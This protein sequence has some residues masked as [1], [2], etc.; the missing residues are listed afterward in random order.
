MAMDDEPNPEPAIHEIIPRSGRKIAIGSEWLEV[1]DAGHV[2][3]FIDVISEARQANGV[4][5]LS[6]GGG[7]IE[8][9]AAFCQIESRLRMNLGTAQFLH[10][11]LGQMIEDALKPVDQSKAN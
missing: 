7:V 5:Y 6:F 4:V 8:G 10:R 2:P 3:K 11:L 9:N 1:V